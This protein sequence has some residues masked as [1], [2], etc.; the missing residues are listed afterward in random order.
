ME[1]WGTGSGLERIQQ[2]GSRVAW[3][4]DELDRIGQAEELQIT[5]Y[6][7]DGTLRRWTTIWVVPVGDQLYVRSV[8]GRDADWYRHATAGN[9]A[10]IQAGGVE[11]DVTLQP[12]TDPATNDQVEAAYRAKY[13]GQA[14]SLAYMTA[15]AAAETTLRLIGAAG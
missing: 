5:S 11:T 6:R 12:A 15:P 13:R 7:D 14:S 8:R 1:L 9:A 3:K 10:R 2:G 4:R